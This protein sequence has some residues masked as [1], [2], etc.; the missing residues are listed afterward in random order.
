MHRNHLS[1]LQLYVD[2]PCNTSGLLHRRSRK[3]LNGLVQE[4]DA[5]LC[6][7]FFPLFDALWWLQELELMGLL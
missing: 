1:L 3:I 5:S 4:A 7:G 6:E 2:P